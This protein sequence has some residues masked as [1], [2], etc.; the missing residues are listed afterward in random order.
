MNPL[1]CIVVVPRTLFSCHRFPQ[2]VSVLR[3]AALFPARARVTTQNE[4]LPTHK[5]LSF[6][7]RGVFGAPQAL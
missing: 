3:S 5:G 7:L 4:G 1:V 2:F 6:T